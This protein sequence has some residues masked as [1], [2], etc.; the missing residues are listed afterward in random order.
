VFNPFT[1]GEGATTR[2]FGGTGLGLSIC[3][4]LVEL[5]AGQ[6]VCRSAPGEGTAFT[7]ALPFADGRWTL[8]G[9]AP[10]ASSLRALVVSSDLVFRDDAA[11][12]LTAMQLPHEVFDRSE[13]MARWLGAEPAPDLRE[14][15]GALL[16]VSGPG[17]EDWPQIGRMATAVCRRELPQVVWSPGQWQGLEQI[18]AGVV[19]LGRPVLGI[20]ALEEA[21]ATALG[22]QPAEAPPSTMVLDARFV[23]ESVRLLIAEDHEINQRVIQRQLHRL[24]IRGDIVGDGE[25]ALEAWR[26][27]GYDA[28]LADLHMPRMD[29]YALA[30]AIRREE[31]D[32]ELA[33]TPIIAF[34]ANAIIGDESKCFEAGMDDVVTKPVEL[35]RLR[36]ALARWLLPASPQKATGPDRSEAATAAAPTRHMEVRAL[37]QLVGG[38]PEVVADF[39][40]EFSQG[41]SRLMQALRFMVPAGQWRD[42]E[43][44][45]HRLKSSARCVGAEKMGE[46]SEEIENL[47]GNSEATPG[48]V[49]ALVASLEEEWTLVSEEVAKCMGRHK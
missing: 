19:R 44:A 1:Q 43:S 40:H 42:A 9:P 2:R 20:R 17:D 25:Q 39:L 5:M 30:R 29:G 12:C 14:E 31:M 36:E 22:P 38:D 34:T 4:R 26:R 16:L 46:L 27:G 10:Q 33:R 45:A 41:A 48:Q 28:I 13:D 23:G 24:G 7:I 8:S 37:E 35:E 21:I 6:I 32:G 18:Q 49:L 47:V 15:A 11:A 3:K